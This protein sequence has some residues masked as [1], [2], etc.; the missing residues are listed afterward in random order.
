MADLDETKNP[1]DLGDTNHSEQC[2]GHK[3]L[4]DEV[5]ENY[6]WS[7]MIIDIEIDR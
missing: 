1:A 7:K 3:V 5:T 6:M 2:R 4:L